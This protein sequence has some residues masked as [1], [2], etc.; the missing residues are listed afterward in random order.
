MPNPNLI[1]PIDITVQRLNRGEL[2]MDEDAREPMHGA[3]SVSADQVVI[4]AQVNWGAKGN[5]L[6]TDLG[7]E[8]KSDGYILC[9]TS[10]LRSKGGSFKRGDKIITMGAGDNALTG[11]DL[12]I[13]K[14]EPMGH[15]PDQG[16]SSMVRFHFADRKPVQQSGNL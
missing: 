2:V 1:H 11:L 3:R 10:D 15:W 12:Y 14:V 4:K 6:F 5:P 8:E 16:G 13:T 7:P 9:R